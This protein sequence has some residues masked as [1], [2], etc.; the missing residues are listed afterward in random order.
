MRFVLFM[1]CALIATGCSDA[2]PG[3]RDDGVATTAAPTPFYDQK[4]GDNYL[5]ISALSD[6][7][8]EAGKKAP[9]VT[10]FRFAGEKDGIYTL[11][12]IDS[13]GSVAATLECTR[14]C[15]IVSIKYGGR[16]ERMGYSEESVM[17]AAFQDA[18]N[19]FLQPPAK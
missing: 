12:S 14:P 4:E 9:D 15:K 11:Q 19:G 6:A 8:K 13:S 3:E 17:G 7:D 5:Y 1:G 18:F 10:T 2:P 16:T